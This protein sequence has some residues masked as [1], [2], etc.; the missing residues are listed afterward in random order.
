[1]KLLG[2]L[3]VWLWLGTL[4]ADAGGGGKARFQVAVADDASAHETM[5]A[6]SAASK[7]E[8]ADADFP[9]TGFVPPVHLSAGV[10]PPPTL[11]GEAWFSL[12]AIPRRF[13]VAWHFGQGPPS[14]S[15]S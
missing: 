8:A 11:A 10:F 3:G 2:L 6:V 15:V 4:L 7:A 9:T 12:G 5:A 14:R 13:R 1:M